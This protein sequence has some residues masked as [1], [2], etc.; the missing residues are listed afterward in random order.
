VKNIKLLNIFQY[1]LALKT[2]KEKVSLFGAGVVCG[3]VALD[4]VTSIDS[5]ETRFEE[6][7]LGVCERGD[8]SSVSTVD[9]LISHGPDVIGDTGFDLRAQQS[10]RP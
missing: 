3:G 10:A 5:L 9:N 7:R 4:S 2:P 1:W 8:M 6:G